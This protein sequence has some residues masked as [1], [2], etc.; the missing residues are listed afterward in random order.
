MVISRPI[1]LLVWLLGVFGIMSADAQ[2]GPIGPESLSVDGVTSPDKIPKYVKYTSLFLGYEGD[3]RSKLVD[4]LPPGDDAKIM[5]TVASHDSW[6][7]EE[8]SRNHQKMVDLCAEG[9][10]MDP[11]AYIKKREEVAAQINRRI[12]SH[13]EEVL[14]SLS[15]TGRR[16]IEKFIESEITP[17]ISGSI[18]KVPLWKTMD[19]ETAQREYELDCYFVANGRYP[20]DVESQLKQSAAELSGKLLGGAEEDK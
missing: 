15:V 13:F 3:Y 12:T 1:T 7:S 11:I 19:A 10:N 5:S 2:N 4:Q 9:A 20:P 16:I 17:T 18:E 14:L 6:Q 8:N